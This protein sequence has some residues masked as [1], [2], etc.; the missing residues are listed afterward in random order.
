M[1]ANIACS[2]KIFL[3]NVIPKK[4]YMS[5]SVTVIRWLS[6]CI[7]FSG[8]C[9]CFWCCMFWCQCP[10]CYC[11]KCWV[12]WWCCIC[13]YHLVLPLL[14]FIQHFLMWYRS[15]WNSCCFY[16]W[17]EW[18]WLFPASNR[19]SLLIKFQFQCFHKDYQRFS[20]ELSNHFLIF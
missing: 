9:C 5:F 4:M 16:C 18:I 2:R 8:I 20:F 10:L 3:L 1:M 7:I 14:L 15:C 12:N 19:E 17:S 11:Y 6:M 13:C